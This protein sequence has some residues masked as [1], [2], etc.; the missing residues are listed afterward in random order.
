MQSQQPNAS[1]TPELKKIPEEK[2]IELKK[3]ISD[4]DRKKVSDLIKEGVTV[5]AKIIEDA[6]A[7]RQPPSIISSRASN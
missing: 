2:I 6:I 1:P 5:D 7:S 4:F 3:A